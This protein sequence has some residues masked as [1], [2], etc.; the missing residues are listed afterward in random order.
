[1]SRLSV[2][3]LHLFESKWISSNCH[4]RQFSWVNFIVSWI[5]CI[6]NEGT[7]FELWNW[8]DWISIGYDFPIIGIIIFVKI[9]IEWLSVRHPNKT[10][11]AILHQGAPANRRWAVGGP[12]RSRPGAVKEQ[13]RSIRQSQAAR[14]WINGCQG[15]IKST[16][17]LSRD[18]KQ[19]REATLEQHLYS[20]EWIEWNKYLLTYFLEII[21]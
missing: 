3:S 14:T 19:L 18:V 1:M 11:K 5:I 4:I 9:N 16:G 7:H 13:S 6:W 12:S 21:Q 10:A 2:Q 15:N 8:F 20:F 17:I